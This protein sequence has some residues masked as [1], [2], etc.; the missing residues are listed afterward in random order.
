MK[1]YADEDAGAPYPL[2]AVLR[3]RPRPPPGFHDP[4]APRALEL[5]EGARA[6]FLGAD[7]YGCPATVI[8]DPGR[9]LGADGRRLPRSEE[10]L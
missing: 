3:Q 7:H 6:L 4:D 8:A 9:G 2:Q 10:R 1:R 5:Q